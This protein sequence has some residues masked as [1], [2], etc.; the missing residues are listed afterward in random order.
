VGHPSKIKTLKGQA[1]RIAF[2]NFAQPCDVFRGFPLDPYP[3]YFKLRLDHLNAKSTRLWM[4]QKKNPS[5]AGL[6][7]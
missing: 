3:E 1:L 4:N 2:D 7:S 5:G 6:L